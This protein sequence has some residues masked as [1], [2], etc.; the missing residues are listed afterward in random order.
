MTNNP[1]KR[2]RLSAYGVQIVNQAPVWTTPH[3]EVLTYLSIKRER[4]HHDIDLD[5]LSASAVSA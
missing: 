2:R 4:M 3:H 5:A 1:D